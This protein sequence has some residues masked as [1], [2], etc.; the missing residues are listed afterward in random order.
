MIRSHGYRLSE[1]LKKFLSAVTVQEATLRT[2]YSCGP[3][4]KACPAVWKSTEVF[5]L[6]RIFGALSQ[7]GQSLLKIGIRFRLIKFGGFCIQP[8][9]AASIIRWWI[10]V[11]PMRPAWLNWG[12]LGCW[13]ALLRRMSCGT[14]VFCIITWWRKVGGL[15]RWSL[16]LSR[17]RNMPSISWIMSLKMPRKWSNAWLL[18]FSSRLIH[19]RFPFRFQDFIV[20][21]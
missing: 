16:L 20:S 13:W 6:T 7:L 5:W 14:D 1:T 3:A 15:E 9:Q 17:A 19:H 8:R 12:V 11:P 18:F 10:F 4:K 2:I 21:L